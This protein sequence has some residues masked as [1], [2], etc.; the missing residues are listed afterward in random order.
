MPKNGARRRGRNYQPSS[1]EAA[2]HARGSS[3]QLARRV[4][5]VEVA[6]IQ[7]RP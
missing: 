1:D 7:H 4:L 2:P 5:A 6:T 3:Q